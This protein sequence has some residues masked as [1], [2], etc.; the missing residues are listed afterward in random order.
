MTVFSECAQDILRL[1]KENEVRQS[2]ARESQRELD[3][4]VNDLVRLCK[5]ICLGAISKFNESAKLRVGTDLIKIRFS[6]ESKG[7]L[8]A[9]T[10]WKG[11]HEIDGELEESDEEQILAN[12]RAIL[13][14]RLAEA[15]IDLVLRAVVFPPDYYHK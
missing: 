2:A 5:P 6:L 4:R 15:N 11:A 14:P 9:A 8:I 12:L 1:Q 3:R 7:L 13:N 10:L